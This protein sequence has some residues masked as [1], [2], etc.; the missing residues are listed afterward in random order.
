MQLSNRWYTIIK[1]LAQLVFPAAGTL[2][3]ALAAIWN[4]PA[5]QQ[6]VGTVIAVDTF[7]GVILTI[8]SANY[9][10]PVDGTLEVDTHDPI[11]NTFT[12]SMDTHPQDIID[13]GQKLVKLAVTSA[14]ATPPPAMMN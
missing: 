4:L 2:Y 9:K 5:A 1:S 3:F 8:S 11:K 7:L 6:V 13:K 14:P 12:L 10:A